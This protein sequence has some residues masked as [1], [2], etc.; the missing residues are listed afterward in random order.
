M[1]DAQTLGKYELRGTLGKGA[2]GTVYDGWDPRIGRRV[3]IKTVLLP[4][5]PDPQTE[6]EIARF[7]REAQAAGSLSHPN[8]VGV[9]DYGETEQQ[10]YI[11]MEFVG[12]PSLKSLLDKEERFTIP[13]IAGL[14]DELLAG[15]QFS[16]AK[17]VVHRD[18]KPANIMLTTDRHVKIADFGI[19][20]IEQS[21]MTQAGTMMGTPAYM[22]PEQFMGQTVDARTD[23]YAAGVVLYQLLTGERPFEG[24]LTTIMQ[25]VLNTEPLPPSQLSVVAPR[26]L[27]AVVLKALAKRP[28]ARWASAADFAKAI[29]AAVDAAPDALDALDGLGGP[30]D[31]D[32][33]LVARP[34]AA[35]PAAADG[36]RMRPP[37][38]AA[39]PAPP[40][41]P[42]PAPAAAAKGGKGPIIA[43]AAV[44][45]VVVLG[46]GGYV[47]FGSSPAP[48]P[49][50]VV[51]SAPATPPPATPA[52][53]PA[54]PTPPAP[55]VSQQAPAQPAAAQPAAAQPPAAQPAPVQPAA[56]PAKPV[57]A[58]PVAAESA[59]PKTAPQSAAQSPAPP[60]AAAPAV[61]PSPAPQPATKLAMAP[62]QTPA[63]A[64]VVKPAEPAA[65]AAQPTPAPSAATAPPPAPASQPSTPAPAPAPTATPPVAATAPAPAPVQAI[66]PVPT[67]AQ[68]VTPPETAAPT[69]AALRPLVAAALPAARC[70]IAI[71]DVPETGPVVLTG[72]SGEPEVLQAQIGNA[73]GAAREVRW[74]G[75]T[76]KPSLCRALDT[77][78]SV[79]PPGGTGALA[80]DLGGK[81]GALREDELIQPRAVMPDFAGQ[82]RLDYVASDGTLAHLFPT[83]ADTGPKGQKVAAQP[84]RPLAAHETVTLGKP[85][86]DKSGAEMPTWPVGEPFGT[87]M[88][89]AIASASPLKLTN[90][91]NYE[92]EKGSAAYLGRLAQEIERVQRAGEKITG[93]V[94]L[95]HTRPK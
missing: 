48:K 20:R 93:S 25:K 65:T 61:A 13:A 31:N 78:R 68:A 57:Q 83:A 60:P 38:A 50:E 92:D 59:A 1:D 19:A 74:H 63:P 14:M 3:A 72:I 9:Y 27:D 17:G 7:R 37:P 70:A 35:T 32:A 22:S 41:A 62:A 29:R 66:A 15:L 89:V 23:V 4:E 85:G 76:V 58:A 67:V 2:M 16:H 28:E 94:V 53:A 64:P 69:A 51:A 73:I 26:A 42:P 24:G 79:V 33:T 30:T 47:L 81:T 5:N 95:V 86:K 44:V 12:G 43:I 77:V 6:E 55:A 34:S 18:I 82:L 39:P 21:S 88:M 8:I 45:A 91:T 90:A 10:A 87:D 49:P 54:Q 71:A 46:G 40:V 56:A 75:E 52:A 80:L 36:T 84:A 11:V